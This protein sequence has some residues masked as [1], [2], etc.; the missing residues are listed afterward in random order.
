[1]ASLCISMSNFGMPSPLTGLRPVKK[2]LKLD[3]T[4]EICL[5]NFT[6]GTP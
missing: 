2:N 5:T 1:M 4:Y 3:L 6:Y